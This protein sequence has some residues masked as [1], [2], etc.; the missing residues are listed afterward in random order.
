LQE[1]QTRLTVDR[2][3]YG[4]FGE[5]LS[6][7]G[8]DEKSVCIGDVWSV[9][10]VLFEVSQPRQ[11][12]WKLARRWNFKELPKLVVQSARSGWY[13][14]VK[15]TGQIQAN[16]VV[17]LVSRPNPDWTVHAANRVFYGTSRDERRK[18]AQVPGLSAAWQ[19]SL[20]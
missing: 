10:T 11:P 12:C 16:D 1:F 13:F 6:I 3:P 5:N 9:G 14:R 17:D 8:L 15:R 19:E 7:T 4:G 18:L 2:I 20:Q